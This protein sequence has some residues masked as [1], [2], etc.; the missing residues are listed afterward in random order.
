LIRIATG[1]IE[2]LTINKEKMF[3]ALSI[4]LLATD[5]A[6]YLVRKGVRSYLKI[7]I[8]KFIL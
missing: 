4:D 8:N 5:L 7:I 3:D 1:V 2:S 6:Y